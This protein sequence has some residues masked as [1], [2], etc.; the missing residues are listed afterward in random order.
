MPS[1]M[2]EA[3]HRTRDGPQMM[4]RNVTRQRRNYCVPGVVGLS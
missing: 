4:K 1:L 2:E 3:G